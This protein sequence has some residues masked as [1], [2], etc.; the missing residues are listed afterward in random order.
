MAK[1]T[2]DKKAASTDSGVSHTNGVD[3]ITGPGVTG[4]FPSAPA[5]A[6]EDMEITRPK[7]SVARFIVPVVLVL[8]VAA[9]A[10]WWLLQ[11]APAADTPP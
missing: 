11:P 2:L 4:G 5:I 9:V 7:R 6:G 1:D 8:A 10:A 3:N